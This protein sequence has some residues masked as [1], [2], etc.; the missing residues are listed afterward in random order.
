MLRASKHQQSRGQAGESVDG[1]RYAQRP[2]E[3]EVSRKRAA[4][5]AWAKQRSGGG[6]APQEAARESGSHTEM[7]F[8]MRLAA[9]AESVAAL[10]SGSNQPSRTTQKQLRS[11]RVPRGRSCSDSDFCRTRRRSR[12]EPCSHAR[13]REAWQDFG[14]RSN[15]E[16]AAGT[17]RGRVPP[18]RERVPSDEKTPGSQSYECERRKHLFYTKLA[19]LPARRSRKEGF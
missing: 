18:P 1:D 7:A 19:M 9:C 13:S 12:R 15:P 5:K 10:S 3:A 17:I 6:S 14:H 11:K 4:V 8:A 16:S 2:A